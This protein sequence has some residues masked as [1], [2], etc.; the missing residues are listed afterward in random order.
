MTRL[1]PAAALAAALAAS[2]APAAPPA[3]TILFVS[4]KDHLVAYDA[5]TGA[6][7][8]RFATPGLSADMLVTPEG[9]LVLNHRD[10]NQVLLVD[11]RSLRE[12]GRIASSTIGG[13]RPV[14]LYLAPERPDGRRLVLVANDGNPQRPTRD[15]N[16]ALI[17]DATDPAAPRVAGEVRLGIGHHKLAFSRDGLRF[18]ASNIADCEEVVGVY[19]IADPARPARLLSVTGADL[20]LDGRDGRPA[21]DPTGRVGRRPGPHGTATFG[22]NGLHAHNANGTGQF[23][24]LDAEANPPRLA[25]VLNT[26]GGSGG[27]S[28]AA[29]PRGR[30]AYGPQNTPRADRSGAEAGSACQIGQL[31]VIDGVEKRLAA[32]VPILYDAGCAALPERARGARPA[33]AFVTADGRTLALTVGTLNAAQPGRA[34]MLV[35]FDLADPARP[36]QV[37]SVPVGAAAGHRDAA[38]TADGRIL[39]VPGNADASVTI[40]DLVERRA[41]RR[42]AVAAEPN[43]VAAWSPTA[44]PTKAPGTITLAAR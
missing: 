17:I 19:D 31:A 32:E 1:L 44:G 29:H 11:A 28:I 33:Y 37:A 24:L 23:I 20:G 10:A 41:V 13:T 9:L 30:Y 2:P 6:E 40:V 14:H 15:D 3:D 4:A 7:R 34:E 39:F 25:A 12:V 21:C 22:A 16:S 18:S 8:A 5:A 27:A 38:I 42:L 43:R 36:T 26:K 35:L